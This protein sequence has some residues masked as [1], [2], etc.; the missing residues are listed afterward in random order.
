[1]IVSGVTLTYDSQIHDTSYEVRAYWR[2]P[3]LIARASGSP[4]SLPLILLGIAAI[5]P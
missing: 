4:G 2:G 3:I 1:M 5:G